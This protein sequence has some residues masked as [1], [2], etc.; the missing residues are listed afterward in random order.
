MWN[1]GWIIYAVGGLF[2][3][4]ALVVGLLALNKALQ[5]QRKTKSAG[6]WASITGTL[7]ESRVEELFENPGDG[8]RTFRPVI[9][10]TYQVGGVDYEGSHL[11]VGDD[12]LGSKAAMEKILARYP[13]GRQVLVYYNPLKPEESVLEKQSKSSTKALILGIAFLLVGIC[14]ACYTAGSVFIQQ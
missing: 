13:Q 12:P 10:Y 11:M 14:I 5:E 2:S 8:P 1:S 9:R 4:I 3:S 6:G 7:H